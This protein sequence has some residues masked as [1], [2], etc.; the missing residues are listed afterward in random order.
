MRDL[1]ADDLG[2]SFKEEKQV[3][4]FFMERQRMGGFELRKWNKDSERFQDLINN[5]TKG[6]IDENWMKKILGFD[7]NITSDEIIFY[8]TDIVNKASN[9]PVTERNVLKLSPVFFDA[10]R[11]ICPIVLQIKILFKEACAL[12]YTWDDGLNDEFV[13]K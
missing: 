11:L 12:K 13:E 5:D 2:F 4:Q 3:F 1:Y 6:A 8:F 10:L 9:L 7:W